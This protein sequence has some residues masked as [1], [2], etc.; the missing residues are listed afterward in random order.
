MGLAASLAPACA[1]L[2]SAEPSYVVEQRLRTLVRAP[3]RTSVAR[4]PVCH[5]DGVDITVL[6]ANGNVGQVVVREAL[7][8]GHRVVALVHNSDPFE[9][10]A[11][12][13]VITGDVRDAATMRKVA[14]DSGAVISCLGTFTR[15][16]GGVL[17]PAMS[18]LV[19]AGGPGGGGPVVTLTGA[20]AITADG[21]LQPR[22][23]LYRAVL[24]VMD[25][26]AVADSEAHLATLRSS[27]LA[28]TTLCAPSITAEGDGEY[29]LDPTMPSLRRSTSRLAVARALLDV[30][31]DAAAHARGAV[32]I[33]PPR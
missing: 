15:K 33:H 2:A 12:L 28:W 4:L 23:R 18:A 7:G 30:A 3:P 17:G 11:A 13:T 5:D 32:G 6:G 8:R 26:A 27:S 29:R 21:G 14:A 16:S 10:D 1:S 22:A 20:A 31:A 9:D 25:R 19:E 24:Q